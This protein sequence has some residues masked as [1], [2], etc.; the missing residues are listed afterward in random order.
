VG[1]DFELQ[2]NCHTQVKIERQWANPPCYPYPARLGSTASRRPC[3]QTA[4]KGWQSVAQGFSPGKTSH[5]VSQ[6]EH[7]RATANAVINL[8]VSEQA[9]GPAPNAV[10]RCRISTPSTPVIPSAAFREW[11]SAPRAC[12]VLP[13]LRAKPMETERSEGVEWESAFR[14][15]R[16]PHHD[17][18]CL[19]RSIISRVM[20][21]LSAIG[22]GTPGSPPRAVFA[23]WGG[24][25]QPY[26]KSSTPD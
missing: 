5:N 17:S 23:C 10:E 8:L 12:P 22:K 6:R 7:W 20:R 25:L 1:I 4:Q 2:Q 26:Q 24:G 16:S 18:S 9:S 3:T 14:I 11:E 13:K 21:G 15:K 19:A